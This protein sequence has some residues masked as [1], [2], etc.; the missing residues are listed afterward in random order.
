MR[1][2]IVSGLM[3]AALATAQV[4]LAHGR[5]AIAHKTTL[6]RHHV[7]NTQAEIN[8]L[9]LELASLTRPERLRELAK[10]R[11]NMAPPLPMQVWRP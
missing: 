6:A 4:W 2:W 5:Y 11:L 7:E 10:Q 1:L 3:M 8:R 9:G